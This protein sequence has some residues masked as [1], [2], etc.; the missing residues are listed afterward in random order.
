MECTGCG[1]DGGDEASCAACAG[2]GKETFTG[3]PWAAI[4]PDVR[5]ALE[6]AKQERRGNWPVA[7][8]W[9]QQTRKCL[10]AIELIRAVD[11][12]PEPKEEAE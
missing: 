12:V 2:R 3:C 6:A 8:G 5:M 11:V 4:T 9:L 1:G 10:D 7:G